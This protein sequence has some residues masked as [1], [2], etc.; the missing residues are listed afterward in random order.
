MTATR[1]SAHTH[2]GPRVSIARLPVTY[3]Q[4]ASVSKGQWAAAALGRRLFDGREL[5]A[6]ADRHDQTTA[7]DRGTE[8]G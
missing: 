6:G 8:W 1:A 2:T 3:A 7:G 4:G 5:V